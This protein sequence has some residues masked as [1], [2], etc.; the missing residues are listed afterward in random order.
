MLT[1]AYIYLFILECLRCHCVDSYRWITRITY[2]VSY[3]T[4][5]CTLGSQFIPFVFPP[6]DLFVHWIK[7]VPMDLLCI[8]V[9]FPT[10]LFYRGQATDL[11]CVVNGRE[12]NICF[13]QLHVS[14]M[15]FKTRRLFVIHYILVTRVYTCFDNTFCIIK[16]LYTLFARQILF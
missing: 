11:P 9:L 8:K 15:S 1:N 4:K 3:V 13:F 7:L 5:L 12:I 6:L 2:N 14:Q 10:K 16:T